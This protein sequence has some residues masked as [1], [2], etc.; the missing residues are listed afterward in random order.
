MARAEWKT[1]RSTDVFHRERDHNADDKQSQRSPRTVRKSGL[2]EGASDEDCGQRLR[3]WCWIPRKSDRRDQDAGC[4]QPQHDLSGIAR[5]R[6]PLRL[7]GVMPATS[8]AM[9]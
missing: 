9:R 8:G 6:L 1:R 4:C 7:S 2:R 3:K 5:G